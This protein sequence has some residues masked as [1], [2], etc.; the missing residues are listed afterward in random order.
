MRASML[1]VTNRCKRDFRR[2]MRSSAHTA[3]RVHSVNLLIATANPKVR[4]R[5]G[6]TF[7]LKRR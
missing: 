5:T 4:V 7:A 1:P 2:L 6:Y 3:T